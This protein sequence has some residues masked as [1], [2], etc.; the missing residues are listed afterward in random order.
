MTTRQAVDPAKAKLQARVE[1]I[2]KLSLEF[3]RAHLNEDYERL[4]E[5]LVLKLSRKRPSP[6]ATG[7]TAIW[8]GSVLYALGQVNFLFDKSNPPFVPPATIAE[9]FG[10]TV[11]T[12]GGKAKAI[13][14]MF[15]MG[16]WDAEFSTRATA[17]TNPF[18]NMVMVNGFILPIST[19]GDLLAKRRGGG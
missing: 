7:S 10:T 12:L 6:L 2:T 19:P 3:A 8:A 17:A 15:K 16:Y 9:H 5:A 18:A 13:R 4:A 14:T 1:E 11:A